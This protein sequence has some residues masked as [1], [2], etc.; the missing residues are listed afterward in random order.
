MSFCSSF[1]LMVLL[2]FP[3]FRPV[4]HGTGIKRSKSSEF[5]P[6]DEI[7]RLLFLGFGG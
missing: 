4:V 5:L 1:Y 6:F 7:Y 3:V 2:L